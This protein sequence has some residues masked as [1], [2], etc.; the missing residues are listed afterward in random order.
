M[1]HSPQ[2]RPAVHVVGGGRYGWRVHHVNRV[3]RTRADARRV[4]RWLRQR[5]QRHPVIQR[6]L[7]GSTTDDLLPATLRSLPRP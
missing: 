7:R 4:A 2:E 6:M 1:T 3:F 5:S